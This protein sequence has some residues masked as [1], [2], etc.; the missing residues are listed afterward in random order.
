MLPASLV[1]VIVA[2]VSLTVVAS[3]LA[4]H[5][6]KTRDTRRLEEELETTIDELEQARRNGQ[7]LDAELED[8]RA[9]M[10]EA[11]R[12]CAVGALTSGVAHDINNPLT[13]VSANLDTLSEYLK[14]LSE[15]IRMIEDG[16]LSGEELKAWTSSET[17]RMALEDA[18]QCISDATEGCRRI[19]EL[20]AGISALS[21]KAGQAIPANLG[22]LA[23]DSVRIASASLKSTRI[24]THLEDP[25]PVICSEGDMVRVLTN[26]IINA[27]QAC[28]PAGIISV[29]GWREGEQV[30]VEIADNGPGIPKN[31]RDRIFEPFFTTKPVGE[32]TGLGLAISRDIMMRHDG[33]LRLYSTEGQGTR[34]QVRLMLHGSKECHDASLRLHGWRASLTGVMAGVA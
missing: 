1:F 30:V 15:G 22:M 7:K 11:E 5:L 24:L 20:V 32:G 19:R 21:R 13:Y 25:L 28:G 4:A 27:G 9:R 16:L 17:T 12:L 10:L 33:E 14:D 31:M 34:F 6:L 26:L 3:C 29:A 23:A 8:A 18:P 2:M